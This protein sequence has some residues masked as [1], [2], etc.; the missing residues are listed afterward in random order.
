MVRLR[1]PTRSS[2]SI[3]RAMSNAAPPETNPIPNEVP[4]QTTEA[5][6]AASA[7]LSAQLIWIMGPQRR[8]QKVVSTHDNPSTPY[9]SCKTL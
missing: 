6:P 4:P 9:A 1:A 3:A 7:T 2:Q 5:R 8:T